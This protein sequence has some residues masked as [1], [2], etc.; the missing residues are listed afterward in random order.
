MF[1]ITVLIVLVLISLIIISFIVFMIT[2]GSDLSAIICSILLISSAIAVLVLCW[3]SYTEGY[4]KC[5]VK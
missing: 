2:G 4:F 1:E 5:Y 3:I